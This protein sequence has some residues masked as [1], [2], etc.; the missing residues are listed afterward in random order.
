LCDE[1]RNIAVYLLRQMRGESLNSIGKLLD[2]KAYSTV[3]GIINRTTT[4]KKCDSKIKKRI[5]RIQNS[6]TS[7]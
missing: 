3:S 1:L 4:L 2:I 6:I 5:E 7:A